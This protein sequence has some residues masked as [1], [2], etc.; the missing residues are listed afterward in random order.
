MAA[1]VV[2]VRSFAVTSDLGGLAASPRS[3]HTLYCLNSVSTLVLL[4]VL[5]SLYVYV[6]HVHLHSTCIFTAL[7][8]HLSLHL[9]HTQFKR[10]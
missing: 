4:H 1:I 5:P 10:R 6:F 3:Q 2:Q 8:K 9:C 7:S